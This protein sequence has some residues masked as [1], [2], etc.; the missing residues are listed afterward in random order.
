MGDLG[1]KLREAARR[2]DVDGAASQIVSA[3]ELRELAD[4]ADALR[5]QRDDLLSHLKGISRQTAEMVRANS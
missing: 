4:E 1:E 5:R 3:D 2:V